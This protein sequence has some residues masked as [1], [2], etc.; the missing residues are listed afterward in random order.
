[1]NN[2]KT[3]VLFFVEALY[4]RFCYFLCVQMSEWCSIAYVLPKPPLIVLILLTTG[5]V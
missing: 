5:L 4:A 1:M 3:T 2:N